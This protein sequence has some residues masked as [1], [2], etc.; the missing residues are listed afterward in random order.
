[1]CIGNALIATAIVSKIKRN[2]DWILIELIDIILSFGHFGNAI[3]LQII[4]ES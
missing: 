4:D 1:M 2:W 3:G